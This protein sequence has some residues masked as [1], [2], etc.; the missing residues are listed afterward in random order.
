MELPEIPS[1]K[2]YP[3]DEHN[4]PELVFLVVIPSP[5][6]QVEITYLEDDDEEKG[7]P[8]FTSQ[9]AV[10]LA[11]PHMNLP[12]KAIVQ[13]R[14][15]DAFQLCHDCPMTDYVAVDPYTAPTYRILRPSM[16]DRQEETDGQV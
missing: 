1:A 6:G 9:E 14:P 13:M 16:K 3:A 2:F 5:D 4:L 12:S 11:I 7:L 15:T 8:V 10:E